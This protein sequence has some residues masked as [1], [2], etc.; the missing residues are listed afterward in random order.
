M[1]YQT[2]HDYRNL[3]DKVLLNLIRTKAI[4]SSTYASGI[5]HA[6]DGV[7]PRSPHDGEGPMST[8]PLF[9][10]IVIGAA[11]SSLDAAGSAL[12][13]GAWPIL[14][15]ALAPVLD[16]LTRQLGGQSVTRSKASAEKAVAQFENDKH[17]QELLRTNLLEALDPIVVGQQNLSEDVKKLLIIALGNTTALEELIGGVDNVE[18][19]LIQGITLSDDANQKLADTVVRRI[20]DSRTTRAVAR[21]EIG[22]VTS[23]LIER[24]AQRIV[25]R[26]VELIREKKIDRALDELHEGLLIVAVLLKDTPTDVNLK[27]LLGYLYKTIAQA[28]DAAGNN[29]E[30][31]LYLERTLS[32]F[33]LVKNEIPAE[34]KTAQDIANAING[35]GNVYY[36]RGDF[37]KAIENYR[38]ATTISPDY[39][40]A[41]H[42]MFGAYNALAK[43]GKINIEAMREAFQRIKDTGK[44][45][46]GLSSDY[47]AQLESD[48]KYWELS[49]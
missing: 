25:A 44:G 13:P 12:L 22:A 19:L 11:K 49:A 3:P 36:A 8:V 43:T 45:L 24:Q 40:Y 16:R 17:L 47:I 10:A 38:L 23:G 27:V 14:K 28:F 29:E 9:K 7:R 42:D 37:E 18:K 26:G 33:E 39:A 48:L 1:T 35:V 46:P 34:Q 21:Q 31:D 41:W 15:G 30:A 6:D 5:W 2:P 20:Q 32:M 4:P